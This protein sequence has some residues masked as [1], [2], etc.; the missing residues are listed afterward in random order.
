V[1]I[2]KQ[3]YIMLLVDFCQSSF[4]I[5]IILTVLICQSS[6]LTNNV[7]DGFFA[8]DSYG[9]AYSLGITAAAQP[10]IGFITD[11]IGA[12]FSFCLW[13]LLCGAIALAIPLSVNKWRQN[14]SLEEI[15][16]ANTNMSTYGTLLTGAV[17]GAVSL[18]TSV[19]SACAQ[20]F[21]IYSGG[22]AYTLMRLLSRL[23]GVVV[24]FLPVYMS[25][26]HTSLTLYWCAAG[27]MGVGF[28]F[29]C[30]LNSYSLVN[31]PAFAL[32]KV[33]TSST[34]NKYASI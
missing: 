11:H 33:D 7:T 3:F 16:A 27:L 34:R 25:G 20:L 5:L 28:V 9:L 2:T 18:Q 19:A 13:L 26:G 23:L 17:F 14:E 22:R 10:L 8:V 30:F 1:I 6:E 31:E 24:A 12:R 4:W 21:G 29:A 15:L 32:E